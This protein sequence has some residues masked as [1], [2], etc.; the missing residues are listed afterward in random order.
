[1]PMSRR[2][3]AV[4]L[5]EVVRRNRVQNGLVYYQVTRG[6]A[7]RNHAFP[8]GDVRPALVVTARSG[9]GPAEAGFGE[10]GVKVVTRPDIRWARGDIKTVALLANVL[11]KQDARE[12][13]AFETWMVDAEGFV[14]EGSSSNAWIVDGEGNLVTRH[15]DNVI[16]NGITRRAVID[17]A[18]QDG[19]TIVERPFD[20]AEAESAREAFLTSA[21]SFVTPVVQVND[22][23]IGNGKPGS[24]AAKL[25]AR[26][27]DYAA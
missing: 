3:L 5:G 7:P 12:A 26:Y 21:T 27:L 10:E 16:L 25:I 15:A 19:V 14:T 20:V 22:A 24:L 8:G 2:A 4:V 17:L 23:V 18:G 6:V 9:L 13:G 11:A 1:M